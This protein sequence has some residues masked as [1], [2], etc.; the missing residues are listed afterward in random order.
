MTIA[1]DTSTTSAAYSLTGTQTTSHAGSSSV[2]AVVVCV[3]QNGLS[4][5]QISGITYGGVAMTR[6]DSNSEATEQGRVYVYYLLNPPTGTQ[7]VAMTTTGTSN[8]QYVCSTMNG[9]PL[10]AIRIAGFNFGT[11]ASA[12]NP[13]WTISSLPTG[14]K[15][16]A[17][18]VIHS[19][20][21]T[22]TTTPATNWTNAVTSDLGSQG[23]GWARQ[24]VAS[25]SATLASGWIAATADDYVGMSVAF[26]E[27]A[28]L[29]GGSGDAFEHREENSDFEG[30]T[31]GDWVGNTLLGSYNAATVANSS[32]R[33]SRG[34]KSLL[35]TYGTHATGSAAAVDVPGLVNGQ[36]YAYAADVYTPTGGPATVRV[37]CPFLGDAKS[38]TTKDAWVTL[39]GELTAD[40]G[41]HAFI[42][43]EGLNSTAGQQT[44]VD[45]V[46]MWA[47]F[48]LQVT[49]SGSSTASGSVAMGRLMAI[50][51]SGSSTGA[52]SVAIVLR[53]MMAASGAS[54]ASGSVSLGTLMPI[55]AS[56]SSTASGSVAMGRLLAMSASG[57]STSAGSVAITLTPALIAASG[58]A[59]SSG[60]V[61][62]T[63]R[64]QVSAAGSS[65]AGGSV[66]LGTVAAM[67]ASGS[68]TASGSVALIA[69]R[70]LT[71]SGA[72]TSDGSVAIT[73]LTNLA[74]AG[75]STATGS[76]AIATVM[77]LAASGSATGSGAAALDVI[78]GAVEWPMTADGSATSAGAAQLST[79]T[80]L[81]SSGTATSSGSAAL[82]VVLALSAAG[83]STADGAAQL[84]TIANLTATGAST[85]AGAAALDVLSGPLTR[86]MA[87][88]GDAVAS[89]AAALLQ[90]SQIAATGSTVAAGGVSLGV[91]RTMSAAAWAVAAGAAALQSLTGP[92]TTPAATII[93]G[94][95]RAELI[96]PTELASTAPTGRRAAIITHGRKAT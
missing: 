10:K 22:M 36:K 69:T 50:A 43:V 49:A 53:A 78:S 20:L 63:M 51:A 58:A 60:S 93:G 72:A 80:T 70:Q 3:D 67:S 2:K 16:E 11:S 41:L 8:K 95:R 5:D 96:E 92:A 52:G 77:P 89:G 29:V 74:A 33:A 82:D 19:G 57:A 18:E 61:A 42:A 90:T 28:N 13:S 66:A 31:V 46:R 32:T 91:L 39:Q 79:L 30:G 88:T 83:S 75:T 55:T 27:D 65:T 86:D 34:T 23:R 1:H 21:D 4:T 7:N 25:S 71:A 9:D 68:S 48:T 76:V 37:E 44:W 45:N 14:V 85:A 59:T 40:S 54:T 87:A 94:R 6:L 56:G 15:L 84:T 24:T 64:A 47:V 81:S 62:M 12:S 17:Y 35:V 38:T 73:R 26:Y